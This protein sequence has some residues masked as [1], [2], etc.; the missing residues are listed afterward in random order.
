ME[1]NPAFR[2]LLGYSALEAAVLT[3]ADVLAPSA[4]SVTAVFQEL[5]A[6]EPAPGRSAAGSTLVAGEVSGEA[7]RHER[8]WRRKDGALVDVEMTASTISAGAQTLVFVVGRDIT[9]HKQAEARYRA[10]FDEAPV[11]YVITQERQG[12]IWVTDCNLAF[13]QTLG[14]PREDILGRPL[15]A[16][17]VH[18]AL[19]KDNLTSSL[20]GP[21][22]RL[23]TRDGR[24]LPVLRRTAPETDTRGVVIGQRIMYID[25]TAD[26]LAEG[27]L[28]AGSVITAVTTQ[29][30]GTDDFQ[31]T[32][33]ILADNLG[34]LIKADGCYITLWDEARQLALP[35]AA[36]GPL[37]DTYLQMR[38]EPGERTLTAA[39]MA[40]GHTLVVEDVLN[41]P[42]LAPAVAAAFPAHSM[43]GLPLIVGERRLGAALI[44]FNRPHRFKPEEIASAERA[45]GAIALAVVKAQLFRELQTT[46]AALMEAYDSTLEG[47][48]LALELRDKET[49]G[50]TRRVT[51]MTVRLAQRLNLAEAELVHVR[52]GALLHDIGKIGI[53]DAILRKPGALTDAERAIMCKHPT[54]AYEVIAAIP[55]LYPAIDIPYCHHEKWDGSGYP[56]GLAGDA[57]PLAA[58]LFAVVDV[59]DALLADRPYR[60]G[61]PAERVL[62][63][64]RSLAGSHFDPAVVEAFLALLTDAAS[65]P[66]GSA[67]P[68]P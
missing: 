47:L 61:W 28:Q 52:R 38:P 6:P 15:T 20:T 41:S 21:E 35:G 19:L 22:H 62:A 23:Q 2:E 31:A 42:H 68:R 14:Y 48:A 25:L 32:L 43:L 58:R 4:G 36:Y 16:F 29:A 34:G 64:L 5:L 37:R 54:Y 17:Y 66:A 27:A 56:R 63:H 45:T 3:M 57:I 46:H 51:E 12:V 50:H 40:A 10:L 39:V 49:E 53:P 44:A 33:Q 7:A 26:K 59:W 60:E 30:A 9:E 55:F 18:T 13:S 8:R 11:M 65:A 24:A 1:T 67:E